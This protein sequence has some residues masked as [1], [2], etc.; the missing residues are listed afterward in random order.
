[1]AMLLVILALVIGVSAA[2]IPEY[3]YAAS[4][5]DD[6]SCSSHQTSDNSKKCSKND[7]PMILPFP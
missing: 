5:N 1:M 6:G 2:T 3:A 7:T 4:N